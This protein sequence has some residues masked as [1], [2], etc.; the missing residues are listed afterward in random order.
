MLSLFLPCG[1]NG[2]LSCLPLFA[3]MVQVRSKVFLKD[4]SISGNIITVLLSNKHNPLLFIILGKPSQTTMDE[5]C[6]IHWYAS[7]RNLRDCWWLRG[8][9]ASHITR[10]HT[11]RMTYSCTSPY[12]GKSS[13]FQFCIWWQIPG[14][15]DV[16]G[17]SGRS[18][19]WKDGGAGG[20]HVSGTYPEEFIWKSLLD[21]DECGCNTD[22]SKR[23]T[24]Q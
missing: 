3:L 13:T 18:V 10:C 2:A 11:R 21:Q 23:H 19:T 8:D 6:L 17:K 24:P 14:G 22:V 16:C 12:V 1:V 4:F 20:L 15:Q 7:C 9:E 5:G